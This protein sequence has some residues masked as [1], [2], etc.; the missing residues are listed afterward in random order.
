MPHEYFEAGFGDYSEAILKEKTPEFY[1]MVRSG[2]A[3]EAAIRTLGFL[4]DAYQ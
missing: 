4:M 3:H 2:A 1:R